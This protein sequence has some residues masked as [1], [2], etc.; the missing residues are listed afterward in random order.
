MRDN[1]K[2]CRKITF[3]SNSMSNGVLKLY[4]V[5]PDFANKENRVKHAENQQKIAQLAALEKECKDL[6]DRYRVLKEHLKNVQSEV[7]SV[8]QL[9]IEKEKQYEEEK[10]LRKLTER[11]RGKLR[12]DYEKSQLE[13]EDVQSKWSIVQSKLQ[14]AQNRI[15]DFRENMKLNQKELDQWE[16]EAKQKEE[17][18]QIIQKYQ[19]DDENKIKQMILEKEN[20]VTIIESRKTELDQ[21]ITNTRSLQIELDNTADYFRKIHEERTKLLAQWEATLKQV[22][23]LD[24]Q[25][26]KATSAYDSRSGEAGKYRSS[27]SEEKKNLNI[28]ISNS[29][30]VER[31]L[32]MCDHQVSSKH[33]QYEKNIEQISDFSEVVATQRQKLD[34]LDSDERAYNEHIADYRN[35]IER[36]IQ[37][38][39]E[40]LSRLKETEDAFSIQK[41][42]TKDITNQTNIMYEMI[43]AQEAKIKE[44]DNLINETKNTIFHLSQDVFNLKNQEKLIAAEVQG[45][46][47]QDKNMQIRLKDYEKEIQKQLELIYNA[48][49]SIAQMQQKISRI[50]GNEVVG[51]KDSLEQQVAELEKSL[52]SKLSLKKTLELQLNRLNLDIRNSKRDKDNLTKVNK[53]LSTKLNEIQIDQISLEKSVLT[54]RKKKEQALVQLNMIRLQI[55]KLSAEVEKKCDEVVSLENRREQLKL[56]L[57]ERLAELE[58][59]ISSLKVQLKTEQEAKHQAI[60]ELAERKKREAALSSKY[61]II[62]GN[63]SLDSIDSTTTTDGNGKSDPKQVGFEEMQSSRI[64]QFAR[65]REN[66]T[67]RG[68]ELEEEVKNAI[69]QLRTLEKQME[70]LNLQTDEFKKGFQTEEDVQ[71][72]EKKRLLEDQLKTMNA[73]YNQKKA[74]AR[75]IE[76]EKNEM[77]KAFYQKQESIAQMQNDLTR[78]QATIE[79]LKNDNK[80]LKD[81][82]NRA[83]IV[84]KRTRDNIRKEENIPTD[85][86]YPTLLLE[87]NIELQMAKSTI[88]TIVSEL[89]KL[90]DGNREIET[91][92]SLGLSQ[93]GLQMIHLPKPP[94]IPNLNGSQA[95]PNSARNSFSY[96]SG[97]NFKTG[98]PIIITPN[99]A[100]SRASNASKNSKASIG[101]RSSGVSNGS[102]MSFHQIEF[103]GN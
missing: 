25:I 24:G 54:V 19:K 35:K 52:E 49:Y 68:D 2:K 47:S 32:T 65:E 55:E 76:E 8:E 84:L 5:L 92:L 34:K 86:P 4:D 13:T 78:I 60:L 83:N 12:V 67:K 23:A 1:F 101:S 91:K 17:D 37:R 39:E 88:N 63:Y 69:K 73:K 71:L 30:L 70:K 20:I 102:Q 33:A 26:E 46:K 41:D 29:Q 11:E 64:I 103:P 58:S 42:Y 16:F 21:E 53:E 3:I 62:M 97:K 48:N 40:L 45:S 80:E 36:E 22:Q 79:K 31:Q 75:S 38:R 99:S 14:I 74:E 15:D 85:A 81:K 7:I 93:I 77:D 61:N 90:S 27:I 95:I 66:A 89:T 18:F 28:A 9:I 43:K 10:H 50:Q 98:K 100:R 44:L 6:Q 82:L 87:M 51:D 59:H 57:Q 96:K 72:A 94:S 56:S